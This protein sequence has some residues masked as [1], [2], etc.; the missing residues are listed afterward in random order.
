MKKK[1]GFKGQKS[2]VLPELIRQELV[3]NPLTSPLYITDIGF[4]PKAAH[5]F[6]ERP[7]GCDE[8]VLIY[9]TEGSGWVEADQ[10][11]FRIARN[12]Y[13]IIPRGTPH[14]YGASEKEPWSIYWLHFAG[15]K[16]VL[17][18]DIPAR[19]REIDPTALARNSDRIML[20]NEIYGN[21]ERGYSTENLEYS[22]ICLWHMLGS[23][24]YLSQFQTVMQVRH[25]DIIEA[26]VEYMNE[27]LGSSL[28]V[29]DLADRA[30]L[31]QSHFS[32]LFRRK[33]GQTPLDF[34][35]HL[36]LQHACRLLEFSDLH[37]KEIASEL[38]FDDPYYFSRL[39]HKVMGQPPTR[40]RAEH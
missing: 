21:L 15:E 36:R 26:T 25:Q 3:V 39:F 27:N 38:G 20:F 18:L 6:R 16:A 22:S 33:T 9:C 2:I 12:T 14:K 35:T 30:S 23:F 17:L 4:Y 7:G 28:S 24:R 5:H 37:I 40:Y 34:Y 19:P 11:R 10:K 29:K 13:F 31:S 8:H 1:E 32:L